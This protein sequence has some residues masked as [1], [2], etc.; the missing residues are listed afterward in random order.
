MKKTNTITVFAF[1]P[2][3]KIKRTKREHE[4]S[5]FNFIHKRQMKTEVS[6]ISLTV[7]LLLV[8]VHLMYLLLYEILSITFKKVSRVRL[9]VR[10]L[11]V[12]FIFSLHQIAVKNI[13]R[14][15]LFV[16]FKY[17]FT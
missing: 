14:L 11:R 13:S 7:S 4:E 9:N 5:E 17:Y 10:V 2:S 6:L 16:F 3:D 8:S 1:L 12:S 15:N